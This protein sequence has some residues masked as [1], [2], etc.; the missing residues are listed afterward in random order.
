ML[1]RDFCDTDVTP[2]NALTNHYILHSAI[3]FGYE[4]D[5]D[6]QFGDMW[7]KGRETYPWLAA[8]I[9]GHFVG[10][11]KAGPWRSR[12]AYCRTTETGIYVDTSTQRRGVGRALYH[13]L[14]VRLA[15]RDFHIAIAGISLPNAPSVRLHEAVGF[16]H[17][18]TFPEVG[19]KFNRWH[20]V[21]FWQRRV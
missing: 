14:F 18:A 4:P 6:A 21:G 12:E 19:W 10:Y 5:S 20:D 11:C 17:I 7:R 1:I 15:A 16:V 13:E 8:D 2:A 9:D 3:H